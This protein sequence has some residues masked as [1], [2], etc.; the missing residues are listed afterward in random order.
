MKLIILNSDSSGNGYILESSDG[1]SLIIECGLHLNSV[2]KAINFDL[3][4]V[5]GCIV[6]HEHMDHFKYH[7]L[8]SKN[9]IDIYGSE[10]TLNDINGHRYYV[11]PELKFCQIGS[12]KVKAFPVEHDAIQPFG[13]IINHIECGNVLFLTDTKS[14]KYK[15][16]G[17]NN[18]IVESNY[19]EEILSEREWSGSI[20]PIVAKRIRKSHMSIETCKELL[21]ANDL[22]EVNNIV[23][24]HLSNGNSDAKNFQNEVKE[25]T[26]KT[27]HVADSGMI[28]EFNKTPF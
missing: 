9:G 28:I 15:F 7:D 18:I 5:V 8:Y 24:I 1:H 12:F 26:N 3:S 17:L 21:K 10:G 20:N 23:L 6:S 13:F 27:V 14:S 11:L 22:S 2:K 19:S 16:Q 25:L 4:K